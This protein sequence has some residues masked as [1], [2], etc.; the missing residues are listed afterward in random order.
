[1][2]KMRI[3][4]NALIIFAK[5]PLAGKVKTRLTAV[6]SP[7][8]AAELYR[9]MLID[10]LF[11][12][13]LLGGVDIYLF[14]E[15]DGD[16]ASYFASIADGMETRPQRGNDLGERMMDAFQRTFERGYE[17]VAII[18]TD[19]P[20]LPVS[21]IEEAFLSLGDARLDAVFGPSE[22]G[23]YYLLALKRLHAEL[24]QGIGWSSQAV[25]RETVAAA[26][27]VGMRTTMLSLWHDVDTVADLRRA[28][29]LDINNG[30]PLT[31][32]FIMKSF[33]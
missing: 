19:S 11:K 13:K 2:L 17:S 27:K 30:A 5:Q 8:E 33:P 7:E 22:D 12:V 10:T 18:G 28:D 15:G 21:F 9:C 23:G 1:M 4:D 24:F 31:R 26:E 14:F 32:A 25:L 29:L 6:L 20:D 3:N 16:A